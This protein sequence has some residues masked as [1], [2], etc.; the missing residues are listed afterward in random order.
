MSRKHPR[1]APAAPPTPAAAEPPA[2]PAA[3]NVLRWSTLRTALALFAAGWILIQVAAASLLIVTESAGELERAWEEFFRLVLPLAYGAGLVYFLT[4]MAMS[5]TAPA[6]SRA[7][8]LAWASLGC[9]IAGAAAWACLNLANSHNKQ[10]IQEIAAQIAQRQKKNPKLGPPAGPDLERELKERTWGQQVVRAL[11]FVA[12]GGLGSAKV[13][14]TAV[15][16]VV[17]RHF[18]RMTLA[19]GLVIYLVAEAG[20]AAVAVVLWARQPPGA[21]DALSIAFTFFTGT[22]FAVAVTSA[23]CVWFLAYLFLLRR[24]LT[25]ELTG[26]ATPPA[27]GSPGAAGRGR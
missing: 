6:E 24:A 2:P 27:P 13:L 22:W 21:V 25:R 8:P 3:S 14:F 9:L 17:A 16:C 7:Q 20:A 4:G 1:R 11:L 26:G 19:A 10:V 12:V 15:L 18:R 5:C 23:L